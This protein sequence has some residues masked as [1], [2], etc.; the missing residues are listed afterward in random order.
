MAVSLPLTVA[1]QKPLFSSS[2]LYAVTA[3]LFTSRPPSASQAAKRCA[4]RRYFSTVA[5]LFSS[6][7]KRR[8]RRKAARRQWFSFFPWGALPFSF[9]NKEALGQGLWIFHAHF[10]KTEQ[11]FSPKTKKMI[12]F[13]CQAVLP[14]RGFF[15]PGR[16]PAGSFLRSSSKAL[17]RPFGSRM[18]WELDR[19]ATR[20]FSSP[21]IIS[22]HS[23]MRGPRARFCASLEAT[24]RRPAPAGFRGP[25]GPRCRTPAPGLGTTPPTPIFPLRGNIGGPGPVLSLRGCKNHSAQILK[26]CSGKSRTP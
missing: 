19:G 9:H 14:R 20:P 1:G 22:L 8:Q 12:A 3:S 24:I 11:A 7:C 16:P 4:S 25:A 2:S 13:A 6:F 15:I 23:I 18:L 21:H 10:I 17:A 26:N 5:G